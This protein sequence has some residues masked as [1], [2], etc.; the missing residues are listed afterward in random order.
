M[1]FS[2]FTEANSSQLSKACIHCVA[3]AD[4]DNCHVLKTATMHSLLMTNARGDLISQLCHQ[5]KI[6]QTR[7]LFLPGTHSKHATRQRTHTHMPACTCKFD[8]VR[9]I[10]DGILLMP[11]ALHKLDNQSGKLNPPSFL[12]VDEHS[13]WSKIITTL[14][15]LYYWMFSGEFIPETFTEKNEMCLQPDT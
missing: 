15:V 4:A 13:K 2:L 1:L 7:W 9:K 8:D 5:S 11:W 10:T 14:S 3:V 12:I 6:P